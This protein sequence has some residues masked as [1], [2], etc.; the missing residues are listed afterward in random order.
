[1]ELIPAK[2]VELILG[3]HLMNNE[4]EEMWPRVLGDQPFLLIKNRFLSGNEENGDYVL[5]GFLAFSAPTG[6]QRV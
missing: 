6:I 5:T 1:M 3:F 4:P 2:T